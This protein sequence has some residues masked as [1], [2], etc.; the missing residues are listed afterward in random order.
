MSK[1]VK[2]QRG[3]YSYHSQTSKV[4]GI[5]HG[6][7]RVLKNQGLHPTFFL[8]SSLLYIE[9]RQ[10]LDI[11]ILNIF[12][13]VFCLVLKIHTWRG[14]HKRFSGKCWNF[15]QTLFTDV[16]SLAFYRFLKYKI[17]F[18]IGPK[19]THQ[20]SGRVGGGFFWIPN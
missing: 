11:F 4:E 7:F 8:P 14:I 13:F 20:Q 3:Q 19:T 6:F 5:G 9:V 2:I 15:C 12:Y 18:Y 10:N 16:S 17:F 1:S